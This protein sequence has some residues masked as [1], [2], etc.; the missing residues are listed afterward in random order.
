MQISEIRKAKSQEWDTIWS[1][2]R[3][4][5][6]FQSREWANIWKAYTK[7]RVCPDG[8]LIVF[9]DGR[10]ALLPLSVERKY[11]NLVSVFH[12][13]PAGGFGGWISQDDLSS[14]HARAL[15]DYL[16]KLPQLHWRLNPHDPNAASIESVFDQPSETFVVDLDGSRENLLRSW[17]RTAREAVGQARRANVKV[18]RGSSAS[19]WDAY[20]EVY[21]DS[22]RRWGDKATSNYTREL[23]D[24]LSASDSGL[25]HLWLAEHEGQVVAGAV[26]FASH[27]LII[28]WHL[29]AVEAKFRVRPINLLLFESIGEYSEQGFRRF[30]LGT[31]GGHE[32]I[33]EFKRRLGSSPKRAP[34]LDH[35][36]PLMRAVVRAQRLKSRL[37]AGFARIGTA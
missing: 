2:C 32:N 10:E 11:A 29:S 18:R 24:L 31:S 22:L 25:I 28:G 15:T 3:Y 4:A 36:S 35:Q 30:D 8:R 13:S 7:G 6:F 16:L 1:H 34:S 21:Q 37:L 27:D 19:D 20:F 23:F 14:E 9:N 17:A 26:N 33:S 5:T 12:S